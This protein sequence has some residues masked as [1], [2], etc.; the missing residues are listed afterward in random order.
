MKEL[1]VP[2]ILQLMGVL[3][4]IAEII[5]PSG[6]LLSLL[7][8]AIFGYSFY[9]IFTD[10][11]TTVGVVFIVVDLI[12][13]PILLVVGLKLLAKSPATLSTQ[14]SKAQGVSSQAPGIEAFMG[15]SGIAST[16]LRPAGTAHINGQRV[17]VVSRGEF[18]EKDAPILVIGVTGNQIIVSTV[19]AAGLGGN[20]NTS[21]NSGMTR[22]V[23]GSLT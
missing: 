13:I 7:A 22:S 8:L 2:I 12:T 11:T 15:Q 10:F 1:T 5:L 23:T 19:P 6:G 17:D 18:I 20:T 14:L 16:A 21:E 9:L 4:I 3:V